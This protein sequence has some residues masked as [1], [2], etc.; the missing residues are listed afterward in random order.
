M[1]RGVTNEGR[2]GEK[3]SVDLLFTEPIHAEGDKRDAEER[4]Q[5]EVCK[6]DLQLG[7]SRQAYARRHAKVEETNKSKKAAQVSKTQQ[8]G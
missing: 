7:V 8:E 3:S 2:G 6:R 1:S 4:V 5:D